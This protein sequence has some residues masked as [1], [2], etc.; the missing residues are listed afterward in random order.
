MEKYNYP[1]ILAMSFILV[2]AACT[3][4]I[5]FKTERAGGQLVI[6]G[7]ISTG[8]GPFELYLGTTASTD[9][10]TLPVTDATVSLLDE[11]GRVEAYQHMG[12]GQYRIPAGRFRAAIGGTYH[13][14]IALSDG[15]VYE[16]E[17]ETIPDLSAQLDSLNFNFTER[18]ELNEYGNI[19][20]VPIVNATVDLAVEQ[21]AE[22]SSFYRFDVEEVYRLSPTDFPDPF[23]SIPPECYV[24]TRPDLSTFALLA[25]N[26]AQS[27]IV[28]DVE[29]AATR[30]DYRFDEKHYFTVYLRSLTESAYVFWDQVDQTLSAVGTIFDTPPAAV[31]GNIYNINDPDEQVL[32]YFSAMSGDTIRAAL[33]PEDTPFLPYYEC[34]YSP[35]KQ[36]YPPRC[37]DCSSVA[38]ATYEKPDYFK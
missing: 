4:V 12:E 33:L 3:E 13:I 35:A 23:G 15:R 25:V 18:E 32:G 34:R 11:Q 31:K 24:F 29:V 8:Q 28:P 14:R 16:S 6:D 1:I 20:L 22:A 2:M 10:K 38:G 30:L 37:L 36:D 9:R 5:E 27:R 19:I 17:R 26:G 7:S 21:P